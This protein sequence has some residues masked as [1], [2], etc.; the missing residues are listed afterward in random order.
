MEWA[1]RFLS[2]KQIA[3]DNLLIGFHPGASRAIHMWPKDRW[4]ALA[5]ELNR[6]YSSQILVFG[7]RDEAAQVRTI[8]DKCDVAIINIAGETSLRQTVS[9]IGKLDF[10]I[11][12]NSGLMHIAASQKTPF[13]A[14]SG[15]A[16]L[17]WSIEGPFNIDVRRSNCPPCDAWDCERGTI[18]CMEAIKVFDVMQAVEQLMRTGL[19]RRDNYAKRENS[20][21]PYQKIGYRI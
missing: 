6:R 7:S 20:V 8:C 19:L 18:E 11:C 21:K 3:K 14:L 10:F 13:I 15:A 9:L 5:V 16:Q 4:V 17:R 12:N 2:A 1:E